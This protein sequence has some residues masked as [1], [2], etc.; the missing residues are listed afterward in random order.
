M[1]CAVYALL[2][3]E[4]LAE[5]GLGD[6]LRGGD[7]RMLLARTMTIAFVPGILVAGLVGLACLPRET[8]RRGLVN[9]GL[10]CLA[11]FAVAAPWYVPNFDR[12][13]EYLTEFGYGERSAEYGASHS[14]V[15]W[16]RWT[17]VLARIAADDLYLVLAILLVAGLVGP[18]GRPRSAASRA[19]RIGLRRCAASRRPARQRSGSSPWPAT[20]AL[21]S[22]RNIGLGFT[23]PVSVLLV[24]LAMP[25]LPRFPRAWVPVL[26]DRA[27]SPPPSTCSRH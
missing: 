10:L 9:L 18:S 15:S 5:G 1:A 12:V 17:D 8:W 22:S 19:P 20:R 14:I 7:R 2:R 25:A 27:R 24:P 6:G 21:S 4:R 3:A 16:D 11:A 26:V 13:A 23:L